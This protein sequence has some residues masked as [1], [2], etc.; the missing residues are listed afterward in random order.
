GK[1]G[2]ARHRFL[3]TFPIGCDDGI[4]DLTAQQAF[5]PGDGFAACCAY[6][7]RHPGKH[8]QSM[9]TWA[10]HLQYTVSERLWRRSGGDCGIDRVKEET[11]GNRRASGAKHV[12]R[13]PTRER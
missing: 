10:V 13:N 2:P 9:T 5:P 12:I 8:H 1:T 3:V 7:F 6:R 11:R 4:D